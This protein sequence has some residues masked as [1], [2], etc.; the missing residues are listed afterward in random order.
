MADEIVVVAGLA[1]SGKSH[2]VRGLFAGHWPKMA[3]ALEIDIDRPWTVCDSATLPS[4]LENGGHRRILLEYGI[5]RPKGLEWSTDP[6][7]AL[8]ETAHRMRV[9]ALWCE[10][11][12][13]ARRTR[14]RL[15][16]AILG[17]LF[18]GSRRLGRHPRTSPTPSLRRDDVHGR[19]RG[20]VR[21]WAFLREGILL[22]ASLASR[23]RRDPEWVCGIFERW[24][25][26]AAGLPNVDVQV[27]DT[28]ST[29]PRV[30]VADEWI[31]RCTPH[32]RHES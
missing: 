18:R 30:M 1:G 20:V 5:L 4:L 23:Y 26:F 7:L 25:Q 8:A 28:T 12:D 19:R 27:V 17:A 31:G 11:D 3:E 13:L 10:P 6:A 29:E 21:V 22:H 16:S 32:G 2:L 15:R 9:L 24:L 14:R